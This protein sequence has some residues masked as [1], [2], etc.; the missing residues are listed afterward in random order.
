[1]GEEL[2]SI[3]D[4]VD[5]GDLRPL[6][7]SFRIRDDRCKVMPAFRVCTEFVSRTP[8]T[9]ESPWKNDEYRRRAHD[10]ALVFD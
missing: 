7:C 9:T 6:A 4:R 5:V 1:M 8:V 2:G 3:S 10:L